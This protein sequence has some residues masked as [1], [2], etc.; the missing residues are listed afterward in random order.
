MKLNTVLK[1]LAVFLLLG[2]ASQFAPQRADAWVATSPMAGTVHTN[3]ICRV[4]TVSTLITTGP[5]QVSKL[6]ITGGVLTTAILYDN[7]AASGTKLLDLSAGFSI[8]ATLVPPVILVGGEFTTGLY[9][10]LGG[11][12]PA[13]TV[14]SVP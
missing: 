4:Y 1:A 9:L 14:C 2:I 10:A 6:I 12:T 11:T 8:A 13:V 5:G 3:G 7:T